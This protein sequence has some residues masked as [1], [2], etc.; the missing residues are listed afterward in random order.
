MTLFI[1]ILLSI[2]PIVRLSGDF[3]YN[4]A[5]GTVSV[6][7]ADGEEYN[8]LKAKIKWRGGVTNA[9]DKHKRNYSIKFLDDDGNKKNLSFFGLRSDN[10]WMLNA[11]QTDYSRIRNLVCNELWLDMS[12]K[13]YYYDKEPKALTAA[14]AQLV[15]V[16]LND[17]YMGIYTMGE[18]VDRKQMKLKKYNENGNIIRGQLWKC[19]KW[20]HSVMM[21]YMVEYSD[22]AEV[23]DGIETVYPDFDEI[24]RADYSVMYNAVD[25]VVNSSDSVFESSLGEYFDLPLLIDYFIFLHVTFAIDNCGKNM[26]WGC[27][28]R[29]EDKK[30]TLGVWDLDC[31][32]GQLYDPAIY[33]P[34]YLSAD[35][36]Y[37]RWNN[38]RLFSRMN[39]SHYFYEMIASRYYELRNDVLSPDSL[40]G[41][42]EHYF[43]LLRESGAAEREMEKWS[44]D[45]DLA[46]N[47]LDLD[48]EEEFIK[49]WIYKRIDYLD[50]YFNDRL[51]YITPVNY[52]VPD[53]N[54][55]Y[56][57]NG[58]RLNDGDFNGIYIKNGKK[59]I[60]KR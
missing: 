54:V 18:Y 29:E 28:N 22:T 46:G 38:L 9:P 57:L 30:L 15:E 60:M 49:D 43:S 25:F 36:D 12:R 7:I 1:S 16:Y 11:G 10:H 5:E 3:G 21:N 59:Y 20:S 32:F 42:Y 31:T 50:V 35:N 55:G 44:G 24:S 8:D 19:T 13:V 17:E 58:M 47:N 33:H 34:D 52:S 26:F 23:W 51:N 40:Y 53:D 45:S 56:M 14:R 4:Y 41:R 6:V 27:Y 37:M 2:L 48:A 39:V